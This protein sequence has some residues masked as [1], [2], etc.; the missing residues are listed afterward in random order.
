MFN[1][2]L[3][4]K[5]HSQVSIVHTGK[6]RWAKYGS[7]KS[8][9]GTTIEKCWNNLLCDK[10]DGTK[11]NFYNFEKNKLTFYLEF[12]FRPL[13]MVYKND[14]EFKGIKVKRYELDESNYDMKL[15]KNKCY[16]AGNYKNI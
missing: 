6:D 16:C 14:S 7:F 4:L 12:L 2:D 15:E 13:K 5:N 11:L 3:I 10:I 8:I 1:C 9:N